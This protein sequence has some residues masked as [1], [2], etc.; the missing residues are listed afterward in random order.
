[1][2][3]THAVYMAV[4]LLSGATPAYAGTIVD[5]TVK[6]NNNDFTVDTTSNVLSRQY[7]GS[8]SIEFSG[9]PMNTL[10]KIPDVLA[11]SLN[12]H[13]TAALDDGTTLFDNFTY[14]LSDLD[15][16]YTNFNSNGTPATME[17][18]TKP[19]LF[20]SASPTGIMQKPL[21]V[22]LQLDPAQNLN[23][24]LFWIYPSGF[25]TL[26]AIGSLGLTT[27]IATGAPEPA[28]WALMIAGFVGIGAALRRRQQ[29]AVTYA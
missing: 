3:T 22:Q 13:W 12:V 9:N 5:F 1:M 26:A 21:S 29:V 7:T 24:S 16:L 25:K 8:G 11:F 27:N 15:W 20:T 23:Q 14:G 4:L 28:S 2:K 17:I 10:A 19:L 18:M 6:A